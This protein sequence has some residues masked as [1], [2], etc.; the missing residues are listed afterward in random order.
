MS[1][2]SKTEPWID[3]STAPN[4][5]NEEATM[6]FLG[7][8]TI[9]KDIVMQDLTGFVPNGTDDKDIDNST[10]TGV[11]LRLDPNSPIQKSP[12]IQ[13]CSAIGGAAVGAF[14]DGTAHKHY[15]G[16]PTPSFK[17][18]CF[19]A[20]TQVLE[21]GV[22]FYCKGTAALEVVSSFTYYAHISYASTHGGRIRAVSGN[23]SYGKYGCLS[24]GFDVK[25]KENGPTLIFKRN[26]FNKKTGQPNKIPKLKDRSGND[27]DVEVGNG[28]K[29]RIQYAEWT[30]NYNGTMYQGLDLQGLQ[31][32]ELV[33]RE[34][35]SDGDELDAFGEPSDS[36][37]NE[38][39]AV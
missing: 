2:T 25:E 15:D 39:G 36:D 35:A 9:V 33:E 38:L 27:V 31:I 24:R 7:T 26:Q 23:S 17:S 16:S 21:G 29:V 22:G 34:S 6:F 14:I 8:H 28:S 32:L 11:Y 37:I 4:R 5:T 3:I 1:G 18:A 30:S 19:D 13:N 20:F 10:I 12:Y